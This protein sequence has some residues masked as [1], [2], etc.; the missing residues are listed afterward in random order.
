VSCHEELYT[1]LKTRS[2]A[3]A[4]EMLRRIR[5][6]VD[7]ETILRY[8]KDGD[9]LLQL[10]LAPETRL[11][12]SFPDFASWPTIFRD[13]DDPYLKTQLLDF[14]SEVQPTS[15][16]LSDTARA[17]RPS[18]LHLDSHVYHIPYHA[19]QAI[20]P[21]LS[22]VR[23]S[24]WTSVTA[25]DALVSNLL[26]IYFQFEYPRT[27]YFQKDL[28]LDDLAR[29]KTNFCSSLLV[30]CILAN[31]AVRRPSRKVKKRVVANSGPWITPVSM[32]LQVTR[33]VSSFGHPVP[34]LTLSW[35]KQRGFGTLRPPGTPS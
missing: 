8:V 18:P 1:L 28:F 6:G 24:A 25:D 27:R 5:A 26:A 30:N 10:H 17:V 20:D 11:R 9:L 16:S 4:N 15:D 32:A 35:Q 21:R 29:G 23:A 19:A 3:E 22:S 13:P 14:E 33:T 34:S 12:Y 7:V 31:A 2:Q